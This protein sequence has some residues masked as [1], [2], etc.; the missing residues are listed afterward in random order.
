MCRYCLIS[1]WIMK[2]AI[3]SQISPI[4]MRF[5][6]EGPLCGVFLVEII[7]IIISFYQTIKGNEVFNQEILWFLVQLIATI[8]FYVFL[9]LCFVKSISR[10]PSSNWHNFTVAA[11]Q[12]V[13]S[14]TVRNLLK[15]EYWATLYR[16]LL[17]N[18]ARCW[19][20]ELLKTG[21]R[22]RWPNGGAFNYKTD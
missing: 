22:T 9:P 16:H 1:L 15:C 3:I 14:L 11:S 13:Y 17:Y 20:K 18:H 7:I 6:M 12:A 19:K 4:Q 5:S 10:W 2:N 21:I 8:R